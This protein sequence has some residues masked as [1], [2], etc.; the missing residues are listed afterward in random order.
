[1]RARGEIRH[2]HDGATDGLQR[3]RRS[4]VARGRLGQSNSNKAGDEDGAT[5]LLKTAGEGGGRG[6]RNARRMPNGEE[7]R[8]THKLAYF[9]N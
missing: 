3:G 1:M 5:H 2:L 7:G 6:I 8:A 4:V 9:E